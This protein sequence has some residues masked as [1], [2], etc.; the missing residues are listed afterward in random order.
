MQTDAK[1]GGD[2]AHEKV[3]IV[4]V[5]RGDSEA[6]AQDHL[7]ARHDLDAWCAATEH[8]VNLV[9]PRGVC[10]GGARVGDGRLPVRRVERVRCQGAR[11]R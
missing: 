1:E 10:V 6:D 5:F 7:G 2:V 11:A 3:L 8:D 9:L 4:E